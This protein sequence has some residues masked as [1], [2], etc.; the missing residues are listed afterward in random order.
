[1]KIEGTKGITLIALVITIVLLL[2]LGEVVINQLNSG[3]LIGNAISVADK[4]KI[5]SKKEEI[6]LAIISKMEKT[7][8][9]VTIDEII[10]ELKKKGIIDSGNSANYNLL[11][12]GYT[13]QLSRSRYYASSF[14]FRA[15]ICLKS[16]VQLVENGGNAY[17]LR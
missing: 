2:I 7:D 11:E 13:G 4:S 8:G 9:D 5:E 1:M 6:K 3:N 14:G 16:N 15:I 17:D 10:E 12:V